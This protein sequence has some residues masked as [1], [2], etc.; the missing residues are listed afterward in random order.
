M[1]LVR[2]V[3]ELRGSK[4]ALL[5]VHFTEARRKLYRQHFKNP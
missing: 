5:F 4:S 3:Y 2:D 1:C